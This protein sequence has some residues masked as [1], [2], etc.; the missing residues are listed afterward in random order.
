M[1]NTKQD[2]APGSPVCTACHF[3]LRADHYQR[4]ADENRK[5]ARVTRS[6]QAIQRLKPY[7]TK[8]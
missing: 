5:R 1:T 4:L 8:G 2:A 7:K 3:E 6:K